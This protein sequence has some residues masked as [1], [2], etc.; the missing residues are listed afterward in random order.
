[1]MQLQSLSQKSEIFD[2]SLYTREP[3][4]RLK[5]LLFSVYGYG[6]QSIQ[7]SGVHIGAKGCCMCSDSIESLLLCRQFTIAQ[8]DLSIDFPQ[9]PRID[10]RFPA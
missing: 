10:R 4:V 6:K 9:I 3:W 8:A 2:S 7:M 1:M 5:F